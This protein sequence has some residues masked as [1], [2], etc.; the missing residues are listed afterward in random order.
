MMTVSRMHTI[1]TCTQ[2][3]NKNEATVRDRFELLTSQKVVYSNVCN[4]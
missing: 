4:V 1:V 3:A 2:C